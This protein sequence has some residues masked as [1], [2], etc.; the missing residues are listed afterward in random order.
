VDWDV[1]KLKGVAW[2][3]ACLYRTL[4]LGSALPLL[5]LCCFFLRAPASKG[6][7]NMPAMRAERVP[8]L[9]AMRSQSDSCELRIK[10]PGGR[11]YSSEAKPAPVVVWILLVP[12]QTHHPAVQRHDPFDGSSLRLL[13]LVGGM[14]WCPQ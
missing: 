14:L 12:Q 4:M 9:R 6:S 7:T 1:S 11:E 2:E 8:C 10:T 13:L 3:V 5:S